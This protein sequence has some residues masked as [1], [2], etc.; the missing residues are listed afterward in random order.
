[1][2]KGLIALFIVVLFTF[3]Y[4]NFFTKGMLIGVY[5]NKNFK[6]SPIGPNIP[7]TIVLYENNRFVQSYMGNGSYKIS[8]S[9]KG[10]KILLDYDDV[11]AT[12]FYINISRIWFGKPKII[13]FKD[14]GHCYE[15]F[16][17]F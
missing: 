12:D 4:N 5:A 2:K 1:M 17:N 9:I 7:D 11:T 16:N 6:H 15:K 13:F 10:T 8:F 14:T 3:L